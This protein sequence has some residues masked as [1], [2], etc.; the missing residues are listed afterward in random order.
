MAQRP[1]LVHPPANNLPHGGQI[2]PH[3]RTDEEL[4]RF[5]YTPRPDPILAPTCSRS[6]NR[7]ADANPKYVKPDIEI[8][9][10]LYEGWNW[11]GA[12][13]PTTRQQTYPGSAESVQSV[14]YAAAQSES[15][16]YREVFGS[17]IVPNAYPLKDISGDYVPGTYEYYTWVGID[18]WKNKAVAKIGVQSTVVVDESH[19]IERY[20]RVAILV[21]NGE[22]T[23]IHYIT[24]FNVEFGDTLTGCLWIYWIPYKNGRSLECHGTL[25]NHG[26]GQWTSATIDIPPKS[27]KDI[28]VQGISTEWILAGNAKIPFPNYGSSIFYHGGA[29]LNTG[30]EV[31]M[32]RA[33][34]INAEDIPSI[35]ERGD[36]ILVE[37]PLCCGCPPNK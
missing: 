34:L 6:W 24:N 28:N 26:S 37:Y 2:T 31:L 9:Q 27:A 11:S 25:H 8:D 30:A 15:D 10:G 33:L 1:P 22:E 36:Q 29:L 16:E 20:N 14:I 19:N 12:I 17:W 5:H 35:A 23:Y 32:S 13:L 3:D 21:T 4:K 7:I 18:G